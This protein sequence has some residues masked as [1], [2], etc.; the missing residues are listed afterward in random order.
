M[1]P[2]SPAEAL[3]PHADSL[4][5]EAIKIVETRHKYAAAA[6]EEFHTRNNRAFGTQWDDLLGDFVENFGAA[7]HPIHSLPPGGQKVPIV[8]SCVVYAWRI[9]VG[10]APSR[11]ASSATK[12]SCFATQ[13][14]QPTLF[15][16]TLPEGDE[17]DP[18]VTR[19]DASGLEEVVRSVNGAMPVVLIYFESS[20]G[21]LGAIKWALA[22][23]NDQTGDVDLIGEEV[24]WSP[25]AAGAQTVASTG[26]E[27]PES[28]SDGEPDDL[29]I[30]PREEERSLSDD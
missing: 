30:E 27:V 6:H 24:I 22:E 7:G 10:G 13:A 3:G 20:P 18:D 14:P 1:I 4:R 21:H 2:Q 16:P 5:A 15:D 19:S 8:N 26:A 17:T 23:L 29:P 12:A 25:D 28:F 11:F 9:P